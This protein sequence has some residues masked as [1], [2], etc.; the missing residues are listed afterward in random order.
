MK[1]WLSKDGETF[2]HGPIVS[3]RAAHE[4]AIRE[5]LREWHVGAAE[6]YIPAS[7]IAHPHTLR[8][9]L[10][11]PLKTRGE[12]VCASLAIVG[13]FEHGTPLG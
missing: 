8:Y 11:S 1:Y 9:L 12:F 3:R 7:A 5:G 4:W 6:H 10:R 2:N 13:H